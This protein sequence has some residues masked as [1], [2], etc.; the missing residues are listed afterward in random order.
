M[1]YL[2]ICWRVI[3]FDRLAFRQIIKN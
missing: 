1:L 3:Y 2:G